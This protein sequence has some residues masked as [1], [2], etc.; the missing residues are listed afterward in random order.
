M[1]T[2]RRHLYRARARQRKPMLD[3]LK[4]LL[5]GRAARLRMRLA[6]QPLEPWLRAQP[7]LRDCVVERRGNTS[8]PEPS[9]NRAAPVYWED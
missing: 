6:D 3:R 1:P 4:K 8:G 7:L 9:L 5:S 2:L